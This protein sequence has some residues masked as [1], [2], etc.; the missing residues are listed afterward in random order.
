MQLG[1]IGLGRTGVSMAQR[2]LRAGHACVVY[3][4][5][6]EPMEAVR[7]QGATAAAS[8]KELVKQLQ[9]PR[10]IW[11]M[12]PAA[13]V[14]ATI[15]ALTVGL[16]ARDDILI[17]GGN[18]HYGD[19]L[20]RSRCLSAAGIHYVDVGTSGGVWGQENGYCLMMGGKPESVRH[21]DPIF[22]ALAPGIS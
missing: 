13:A 15:D 2:L 22:A 17:D 11:M 9:P 19:D 6:P 4:A 14:D 12:V 18:S 5:R 16:L 21:L 10:A 3:D 8:L 7:K 20:V 1:M